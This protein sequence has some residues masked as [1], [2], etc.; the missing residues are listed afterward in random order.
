MPQRVV[1]D[2]GK[3][4]YS[5][6]IPASTLILGLRVVVLVGG[7]LAYADAANPEHAFLLLGLVPTTI[8]AGL[9]IRVLTEGEIS[10]PGWNWNL[11]LPIWL[12]SQGQMVQVAPTSGFLIQVATPKAPNSIQFEIQEAVLL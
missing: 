11:D 12:G 4:Q 3:Q 7:Q 2:S 9:R 6:P 10:N 8:N 5:D 1:A